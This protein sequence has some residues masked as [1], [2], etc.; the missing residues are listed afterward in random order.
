MRPIAEIAEVLGLDQAMVIPYGK[1]KAK[2]PLDAIKSDGPQGSMVVVTGITPTPAGEGKT[3]T[4]V[5]LA[6]GMGKLGKRVTA[7]LQGAVSR[8]HIR[9]QGWRNGR[10]GMLR[11]TSG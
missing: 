6:Q 9:H 11:R 8:P 7:T 4:T 3:T 2:I 5:G 1:Y 10:R